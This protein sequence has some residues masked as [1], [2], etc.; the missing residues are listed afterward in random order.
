MGT[1]PEDVQGR[2][3][4]LAAAGLL[5]ESPWDVIDG[6]LGVDLRFSAR[7]GCVLGL[8]R[9]LATLHVL[10]TPASEWELMS[11][12][13]RKVLGNS[14]QRAMHAAHLVRACCLGKP[15]DDATTMNSTG[16]IVRWSQLLPGNHSWASSK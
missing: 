7:Q 16:R 2:C 15:Y 4:L 13:S 10:S 1:P 3:L 8:R 14:Q 12:F 5:E 9:L 11:P 6:I